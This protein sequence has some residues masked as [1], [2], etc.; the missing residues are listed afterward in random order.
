MQDEMFNSN[1]TS[2]CTILGVAYYLSKETFEAFISALSSILPKGSQVIFDY[3]DE[4]VC[5]G[6][7]GER[8]KKQSMLTDAADEKML[9]S[10]SYFDMEQLLSNYGFQIH[11]HLRP[12]EMTEQYFA[13]YNKANPTHRMSAFG[14]VNYC[15]GVRE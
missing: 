5:T 10:Y 6:Q 7:A 12:Q 9:A 4:N 8:A 2:C 13:A 3:P 11:E 15:L 14:H 1:Q